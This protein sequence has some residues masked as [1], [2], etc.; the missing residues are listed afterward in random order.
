M[1][2]GK[3]VY[4]LVG[5]TALALAVVYESAALRR[6]GYRLQELRAEI[7]EQQAERSIYQSHLSKLRNPQRIMRLVAWLGLDL[8]EP[9]VVLSQATSGGTEA[10]DPGVDPTTRPALSRTHADGGRP[11]RRGAVPVATV[12]D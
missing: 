12:P 5:A 3:L 10:R 2:S 6:T 8:Q 11:D 9:H 4:G 1:M 7:A